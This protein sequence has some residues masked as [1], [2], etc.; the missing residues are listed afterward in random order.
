M[1]E[2]EMIVTLASDGKLI[3]RPLVSDGARVTV[4]FNDD[5]FSNIWG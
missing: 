1:S 5:E 3:K 2:S 4:G